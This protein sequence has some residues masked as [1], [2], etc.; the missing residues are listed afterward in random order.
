THQ[1]S[2]QRNMTAVYYA[3]DAEEAAHEVA[4]AQV[5]YG[6]VTTTVTVWDDDATAA[7]E[8]LREVER[9]INSE[10]FVC[11][12]ETFNAVEALLRSLPGQAYANVR[13]P[14]I[15]TLKL[16]HLLPC[17]ALWA[18]PERN[19]HLDGPP[20]FHADTAGQTP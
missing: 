17:A 14:P 11:Q 20:L 4:S 10:G 19:P 8:A 18:G 1:E 2:L 15:S 6:Y 7:D 13:R 5:A 16:A 3:E 12:R 9:V